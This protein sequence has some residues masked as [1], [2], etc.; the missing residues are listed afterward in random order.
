MHKSMKLASFLGL[1]SISLAGQVLAQE[2]KITKEMM[3]QNCKTWSAAYN[4]NDAAKIESFLTPDATFVTNSE[5]IHGTAALK[6][7]FDKMFSVVKF[8]NAVSTLDEGSPHPMKGNPN[9]I[10]AVGKWSNTIEIT[11]QPGSVNESGYW[12]SI[13]ELVDGKLLDK[14]QIWNITPAPAAPAT[15]PSPTAK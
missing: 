14:M 6:E 11:G 9:E 3:E 1:I 15:S 13:V 7:N 10:W 12:A 8:S 5:V 4:A 2:S